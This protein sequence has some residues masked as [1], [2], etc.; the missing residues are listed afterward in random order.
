MVALSFMMPR[1]IMML[2]R[3]LMTGRLMLSFFFMV[4]GLFMMRGSHHFCR[5]T[6]S[7]RIQ[8]RC[9]QRRRLVMVIPM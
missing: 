9:W 6:V 8:P 2:S 7:A 3:F 5:F 4:I 1:L